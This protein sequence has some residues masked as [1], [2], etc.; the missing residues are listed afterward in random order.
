M[1]SHHNVECSPPVAELILF[2]FPVSYLDLKNWPENP[3]TLQV[4]KSSLTFTGLFMA[5]TKDSAVS[6]RRFP[7]LAVKEPL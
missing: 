6:D 2:S 5:G 7:D 3:G 4:E 1:L